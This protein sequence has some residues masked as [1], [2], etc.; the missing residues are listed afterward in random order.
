MRP[1]TPAPVRR[2]HEV[3]VVLLYLQV[4]NRL[5]LAGILNRYYRHNLPVM[6]QQ[7]VANPQRTG[8]R[9]PPAQH[10]ERVLSRR[11]DY[12]AVDAPF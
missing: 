7:P 4:V 3:R 10:P 8:R 6:A 5:E 9:P 12:P 11:A 2:P 1:Y